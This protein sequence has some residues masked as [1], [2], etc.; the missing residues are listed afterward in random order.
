MKG[1]TL[2]AL[3][4]LAAASC[5]AVDETTPCDE[6]ADHLAECLG[7]TPAA[8]ETCDVDTAEQVLDLSCEELAA[9]SGKGDG[10]WDDMLCG[11]GALCHCS[12]EASVPDVQILTDEEYYGCGGPCR[13]EATGGL[14]GSGY[15]WA[16]ANHGAHGSWQ[17]PLS[18]PGRYHVRAYIPVSEGAGV[19][20]Y[21]ADTCTNWTRVEV[22]QA[23]AQSGWVDVGD[24][25]LE[26]GARIGIGSETGSRFI[27]DALEISRIR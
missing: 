12:P 14:D 2:A 21:V 25:D 3:L 11:F 9:G 1:P 18:E 24:F 17:I 15:S 10:F 6:A 26:P 22:D 8:A 27:A 4:L 20:A 19:A 5:T 7:E 16:P 23:V 13:S